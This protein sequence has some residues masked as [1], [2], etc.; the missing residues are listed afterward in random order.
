VSRLTGIIG[1]RGLTLFAV[2]DH[3]GEAEKAGLH[4]PDTKLV[5]FGSPAAGTT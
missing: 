1:A 3:S 5:L 4:M 2:V